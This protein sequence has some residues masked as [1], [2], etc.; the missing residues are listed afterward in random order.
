M[1]NEGVQVALEMEKHNCPKIALNS[2]LTE[3]KIVIYLGHHPNLVCLKGAYTLKLERGI[4]YVAPEL[5][6]LGSLKSF[7]KGC[8]MVKSE[9]SIYRNVNHPN[10][11][12]KLVQMTPFSFEIACGMVYLSEK[13]VVHA[14]LA[15]RNVLL[16]GG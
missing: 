15:T 16:T 4:V 12:I 13:N 1:S 8:E 10:S 7:L 9:N 14:D 5:R 3:I 6:E 11:Q 2:L